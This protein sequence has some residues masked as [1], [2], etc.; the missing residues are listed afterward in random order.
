M[1]NKFWVFDVDGVLCDTNCTIDNDFK[2][3]FLDWAKGK[4]YFLVTGSEHEKT[5]HQI[6]K[7]IVNSAELTFNCM[8][9][10]V[11]RKG[12]EQRI[13]QFSL[14][15]REMN[16]FSTILRLNK[17]PI[18]TGEHIVQRPGSLN[19][20]I[21]GRNASPPEREEYKKWDLDRKERE[22]LIKAVINQF[23]RFSAYIGGDTSIDIC[24]AGADK[25]QVYEILQPW[26][27]MVF[28]GDKCFKNGIDYPLA[29][30]CNPGRDIVHQ[31][32]GYLE[33]WR[34]LKENYDT[35]SA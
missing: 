24:L 26:G 3:W 13:N 35:N 11:W 4:T 9:N 21:I 28:F 34:I 25:G 29:V 5:I 1:N 30:K 8:G 12:S 2:K 27:D 7:E 18:K 33:T 22:N 6:G 14:T 32:N 15:T 23:P 10:S 20:S 31:V 16:W 17:F 19:F